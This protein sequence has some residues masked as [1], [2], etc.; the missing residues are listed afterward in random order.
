MQWNKDR[1]GS[2]RD[3]SNDSNK[4]QSLTE[5]STQ[6][7][8]GLDASTLYFKK[9]DVIMLVD[10]ESSVPTGCLL[11]FWAGRTQLTIRLVRYS[12]LHEI[13]IRAVLY[14]RRGAGRPGGTG[15]VQAIAAARCGDRYHDAKRKFADGQATS[16]TQL[17][18]ISLMGLGYLRH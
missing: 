10:G 13:D 16:R 3:S 14:R 5:S 18:L 11:A 7:S 1:E 12:T 8:R 9:E 2:D 17:T 15:Y 6:S 4:A